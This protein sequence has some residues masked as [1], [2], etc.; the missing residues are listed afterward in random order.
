MI[1]DLEEWGTENGYSLIYRENENSP[2]YAVLEN[3]FNT[4]IIVGDEYN[5]NER[6]TYANRAMAL[7]AFVEWMNVYCR[8]EPRGWIRHQPS[9]RRRENGDPD[10]ETIRP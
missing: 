2:I 8:G 4:Q 6:Y 5:V 3:P 7:L 10:K 9:N 1:K